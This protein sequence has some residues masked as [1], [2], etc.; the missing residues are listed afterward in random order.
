[1][2]MFPCAKT[3]TRAHS[4]KPPF[5]ETALS[6]LERKLN[7]SGISRQKSRDIPPKS[8]VS[9]G[10]EVH[11]E[12]FGPHQF[13]WKRPKSPH[14][15]ARYPDPKVWV[16]VPFFPKG[17]CG[18]GRGRKSLILG[19]LEVFLGKLQG[20]PLVKPN[21]QGKEEH[22]TLLARPPCRSSRWETN[23]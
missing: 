23:L 13:T 10:F 15:T 8:L 6:N 18:S 16:W 1:M 22:G 3:G 19:K 11:T 5:Y 21:N 2:C 20:N 7:T 9:L 14:P 4:P 12:L 17:F